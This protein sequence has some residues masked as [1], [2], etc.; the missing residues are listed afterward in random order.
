MPEGN[1]FDEGA[2]IRGTLGK[3]K[4]VA[5][6][7]HPEY[8]ESTHPSVAG[9]IYAATGVKPEFEFPVKNPRAIRVGFWSSGFP[10]A[11]RTETMLALDRHPDI[12]VRIVTS[13]QFEEGELR[14]LDALVVA[15]DATGVCKE[16]LGSEYNRAQIAAFLERGGVIFASGTGFESVQKHSSVFE[17][18]IG[19]DFVRPVL[20]KFSSAN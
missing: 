8:W 6:S 17:L 2:V 15:H 9:C 19:A 13:H 4:V 14:H 7:F 3:G 11:T 10:D 20:E 12:D 16:H 5:T 18:P 1:F